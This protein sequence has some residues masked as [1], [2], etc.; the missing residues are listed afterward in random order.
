MRRFGS[1]VIYTRAYGKIGNE[2]CV[3][4][5]ID[6]LSFQIIQEQ[7]KYVTIEEPY[8]ATVLGKKFITGKVNFKNVPTI[9]V[10]T[11]VV[12]NWPAFDIEMKT[13]NLA[14]KTETVR[15]I[16]NVQLETKPVEGV[17]YPFHAESMEIQ[18]YG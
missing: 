9:I 6:T 8:F 18:G 11:G 1:K 12:Q 16:K 15:I 17:E 5:I 14:T 4:G 2:N 10:N 7:T 3:L 13:K